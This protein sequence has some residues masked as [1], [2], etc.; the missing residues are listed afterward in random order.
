MK[1]KPSTEAPGNFAPIL[2]K[3]KQS[4][5][6]MYYFRFDEFLRDLPKANHQEYFG[7][8]DFIFQMEFL[9]DCKTVRRQ[10]WTI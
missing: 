3:G 10:R 1:K 2:G 8:F 6:E 9:R 7:I 4:L 5:H